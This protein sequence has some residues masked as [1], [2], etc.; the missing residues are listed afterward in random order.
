MSGFKSSRK[1]GRLILLRVVSK[2]LPASMCDKAELQKINDEFA[3]DLR[4]L[5]LR[6]KI[7]K[8]TRER[9]DAIARHEALQTK[10]L[11]ERTSSDRRHAEE[12]KVLRTKQLHEISE[13]NESFQRKLIGK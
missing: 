3:S 9:E 5:S 11:A 10:S 7:E 13:L 12:I 6:E 4:S 2:S 8:L 1:F